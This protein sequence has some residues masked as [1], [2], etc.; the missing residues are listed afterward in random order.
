M[1]V[2]STGVIGQ[3]L[4]MEP[5][6]GGIEE[7]TAGLSPENHADVADAIMTT[8]TVRKEVA[9]EFSLG[10]KTCRIGGMQPRAPA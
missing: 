4:P 3:P 2:A 7:L 5:I 10:G 8:D 9:V 6:Q 1:V